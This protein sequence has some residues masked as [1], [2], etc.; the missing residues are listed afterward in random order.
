MRGFPV[1]QN[2]ARHKRDCKSFLVSF[3]TSQKCPIRGE[4]EV[5]RLEFFVRPRVDTG[6]EERH[7]TYAVRAVLNGHRA[8][9]QTK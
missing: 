1:D 2:A 9:G 8:Y 5:R 7:R 6:A 3:E 4:S